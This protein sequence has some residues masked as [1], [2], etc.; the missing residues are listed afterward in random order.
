ML[1]SIADA[2]DRRAAADPNWRSKPIDLTPEE[3]DS[4]A[5]KMKM[6]RDILG[7]IVPF[8]RAALDWYD[9]T[10]S[11][12]PAE[13]I[14]TPLLTLDQ[15]DQFVLNV[16]KM[17][18]Q[19][20][21]STTPPVMKGKGLT[22]LM[23]SIGFMFARYGVNMAGTMARRF[24]EVQG[25]D[26]DRDRWIAGLLL[27]A[28]LAMLSVAGLEAKQF[29][30]WIQGEPRNALTMGAA[31][32]SPTAAGRYMSAAIASQIPWGGDTLQQLFGGTPMTQPFDAT[33]GIPLLGQLT[34]AYNMA[35]QVVQTGDVGY[36]AADFLR[37]SL[38]A[39]KIV[40]NTMMP[41]DVMRREASRAVR[42]NAPTD[43]ELREFGGAGGRATPMQPLIRAALN[44]SF[45]GDQKGYQAAVDKA[46]K[47]QMSKGKTREEA[48]KTVNAAVAAKDP[49]MS[50][51]GRK[52]SD[53]DVER[54]T[55]NMTGSQK[56][57]FLK[58][59]TIAAGAKSSGL[60]SGG[61]RGGL[62][63]GSA[64]RRS[65]LRGQRRKKTRS[66]SLLKS[67]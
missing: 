39:S 15:E 36:A 25:S 44:A 58:A 31:L 5:S 17:T 48:V 32:E 22:G 61:R 12:T 28:V 46:V 11:M 16:L 29:F 63:R 59:R 53:T 13:R 27:A 19:R 3:M 34:A 33:R 4:P 56:R 1:K 6:I 26:S 9:R 65:L 52:L 45:E 23:R 50:V 7:P 64:R 14:A 20:T 38:P 41:G 24:A 21:Q 43:I 54:I 62:L 49:I 35:R 55:R 37:S 30:N 47:Y 60:R 57:S 66:A 8:E 2:F 10:K 67:L 42:L 18:N 51:V 40:L